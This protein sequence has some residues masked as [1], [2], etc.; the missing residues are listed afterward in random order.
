MDRIVEHDV[1]LWRIFL[2][3][4]APSSV[5]QLNVAG[6]SSQFSIL[7]GKPATMAGFAKMVA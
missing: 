6:A 5:H 2:R 1:G 3:S 7:A 4:T